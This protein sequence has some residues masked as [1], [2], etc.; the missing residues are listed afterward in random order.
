[1][2]ALQLMDHTVS[3]TT[4]LPCTFLLHQQIWGLFISLNGQNVIHQVRMLDH[5]TLNQRVCFAKHRLLSEQ[6]SLH[7]KMVIYMYHTNIFCQ[8]A[9]LFQYFRYF[10][11]NIT[12]ATVSPRKPFSLFMINHP[13]LLVS[14]Y[15]YCFISNFILNIFMCT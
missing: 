11:C 12:I 4:S 5:A 9:I 13:S 6:E 14:F 15:L 7:L 8:P 3:L 2:T 10:A 1:M